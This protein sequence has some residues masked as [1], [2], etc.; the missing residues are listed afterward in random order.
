MWQTAGNMSKSLKGADG[1]PDSSYPQW[2]TTANK[3]RFSSFH[4]TE[5][6]FLLHFNRSR[7]LSDPPVSVLRAFAVIT[8]ILAYFNL[9]LIFAPPCRRLLFAVF[10]P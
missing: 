3:G 9:S 1:R 10:W 4:P 6:T 7:G 5:E 8:H 2:A